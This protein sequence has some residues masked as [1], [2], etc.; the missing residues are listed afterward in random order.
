MSTGGHRG[1]GAS[2]TSLKRRVQLG[3]ALA[4]QA[5]PTCSRPPRP[6]R[7]TARVASSPAGAARDHRRVQ[8][9]RAPAITT[10]VQVD[11]ARRVQRGA[12]CSRRQLGGH[13]ASS[14]D[15]ARVQRI[16]LGQRAP[17]CLPS[18]TVSMRLGTLRGRGSPML[19][20]FAECGELIS[21][22]CGSIQND[23]KAHF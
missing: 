5:R 20:E 13:A 18:T 3:R 4:A 1:V 6:C 11:R 14:Q 2:R 23:E 17:N 21:V 19:A 9:G 8:L 12:A 22:S 16:Q 15:S 7:S 10:T